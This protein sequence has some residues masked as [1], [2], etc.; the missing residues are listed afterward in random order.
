MSSSDLNLFAIVDIFAYC[1]Q[2]HI[3][4][5]NRS[6][7]V[8]NCSIIL[9]THTYWHTQCNRMRL[10]IHMLEDAISNGPTGLFVLFFEW[11]NWLID[12]SKEAE[13]KQREYKLQRHNDKSCMM[14]RQIRV[15]KLLVQ[16][17]VSLLVAIEIQ[18]VETWSSSASW[19]SFLTY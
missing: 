11:I 1:C 19:I 12:W 15:K 3:T 5:Y 8:W 10:L 7:T 18:P 13:S 9:S 17:N 16:L 14:N 2:W 4:S 6:R